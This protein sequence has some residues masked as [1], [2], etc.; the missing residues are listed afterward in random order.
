M[1]LGLRSLES[2]VFWWNRSL[3]FRYDGVGS[4]SRFFRYDEVGVE[5][6]FSTPQPWFYG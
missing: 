1:N 2:H 5:N 3:F 6:I 4:R